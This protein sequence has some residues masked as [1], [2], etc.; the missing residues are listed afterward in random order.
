MNPLQ[1]NL[2]ESG[3][4]LISNA[5]TVTIPKVKS[6]AKSKKKILTSDESIRVSLLNSIMSLFVHEKPYLTSIFREL[7]EALAESQKEIFTD[8]QVEILFQNQDKVRESFTNVSKLLSLLDETDA[9]SDYEDF[10]LY[11]H[12]RRFAQ[13]SHTSLEVIVNAFDSADEEVSEEKMDR[14]IEWYAE[15]R[16]E[17]TVEGTISGIS[18]SQLLDLV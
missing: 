11:I 4:A 5:Y 14:F 12:L 9:F 6:K 13:E 1:L 15:E 16:I 7:S 3:M 8:A 18:A 10:N 2:T 17:D